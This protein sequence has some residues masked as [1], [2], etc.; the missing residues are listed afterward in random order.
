M[1]GNLGETGLKRKKRR[2][3]PMQAYDALPPVLRGWLADAALPWS[4][5]S[6]RRIWRRA[7][8]RGEPIEAVLARLERAQ[9]QT[10]AK[11]PIWCASRAEPQRDQ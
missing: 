3:D 6:C 7:R 4:P 8:L 2:Q 1:T 11:D 5:V 10:L 9:A